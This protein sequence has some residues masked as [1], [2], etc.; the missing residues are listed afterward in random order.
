MEALKQKIEV[1]NSNDKTEFIDSVNALL[2]KGFKLRGN[3]KVVTYKKDYI[4]GMPRYGH[5]Y[6]QQLTNH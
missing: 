3:M 5:E 6:I 1:V 4:N 2:E